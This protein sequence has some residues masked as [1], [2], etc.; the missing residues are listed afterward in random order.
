MKKN[1]LY[2]LLAVFGML[3]AS[4]SQEEIVS[5]AGTGSNDGMV[6]LSV[7]L[8]NEDFYSR[9]S[10]SLDVD[11]YVMRCICQAVNAD[12]TLI[13]GF[14]E[15]T[16][17]TNGTASFEFEAPEG[18]ANYLF[19]ADY[20]EGTDIEATKSALYNATSLLEVKY[21]LN[22]NVKLFNNPAADAFCAVA[23]AANIGG[24]ITLKRPLNRIAIKTS[25][26]EKLGLTGLD[27]ITPSINT[28]Q[29]YNVLNQTA[30]S[31]VTCSLNTGETLNVATGDL[32]FYCYVFPVNNVVTKN[33]T[34]KFTSASDETGKSITL[35]VAEMQELSSSSNNAVY[36]TPDEDQPVQ[37]DDETVKVDIVI[38][39]EYTGEEGG[40][41][42]PGTEPEDPTT[43]TWAVGDY[44]S[45]AGAK[46]NTAGEAIAV[47]FALGGQADNSTYPTGKTVKAYA[48]SLKKATNRNMLGT[49]TDLSLTATDD[50]ANAYAGLAF[51]T[52]IETA[53]ETASDVAAYEMLNTF[54]NKSLVEATASENLS[55]WYIPSI[56]QLQAALATT[57]A[58][59]IAALK[60]AY[61]GA[62]Y[63]A[64]STMTAEGLQGIIYDIADGT[65][66]KPQTM[67]T[68]ASAVV[69]PVVTIFE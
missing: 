55:E 19:W 49:Y 30:S 25:D 29:G 6:R 57:N 63:C 2:S 39:N 4:C 48:M 10:Q 14:N 21:N 35:T 38:D 47:V 68:S 9:A 37:P 65:A 59:L 1:F 62:Y 33:T 36:L 54:F 58:D 51:S 26:L 24:S 46:V 44:V 52:A 3:F 16:S 17:V 31:A 34:I 12:G 15:I 27:I 20:V 32:A 23:S 13:E 53:L 11:G 42:E 40:S 66:G 64:S 67:Q 69:F 7:N 43:T 60:G 56:A 41:E 22:K 28:I 18:V 61:T 8:S 50:V 5:T 45:A